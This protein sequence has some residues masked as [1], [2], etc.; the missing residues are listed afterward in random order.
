M[1]VLFSPGSERGQRYNNKKQ[2]PSRRS[3]AKKTTANLSEIQEVY[4]AIQTQRFSASPWNARMQASHPLTSSLEYKVNS[5]QHPCSLRSAQRRTCIPRPETLPRALAPH[6]LTP[7][8]L[9][10][11]HCFLR[12]EP[13]MPLAEA[14][15]EKSP[16]GWSVVFYLVLLCPVRTTSAARTRTSWT[17]I[18]K[19]RRLRCPTQPMPWLPRA[20]A[21][22]A[23]FAPRYALA[24]HT[25]K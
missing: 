4:E 7:C 22:C 2:G 18:L 15:P 13:E 5:L 1:R 6:S 20:E 24:F 16:S 3:K 14:L 25:H 12:F 9:H 11:H 8:H 19:A 21:M 10:R 23:I 17:A